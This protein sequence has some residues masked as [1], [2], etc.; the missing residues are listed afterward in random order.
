M[1]FEILERTPAVRHLVTEKEL[2]YSCGFS[3]ALHTG[4]DAEAIGRNRTAL[5]VAFGEGYRFCGIRQTHSDRIHIAVHP[6]GEGWESLSDAVEADAVI[7][8]L[9]QLVLTILTAD[10]VP[11]LLYDPVQRAIGAVHAGWKGTEAEIVI[12]T[13]RKMQMQYGSD[14][15]DIIVAIGPAIGQCC[16]EVGGEVAEHFMGYAGAVIEGNI[17]GKY[18]LDLKRV[19]QLQAEK[20]GISA[21]HIEL[22]PLCTSCAKERFFSY[23]AEQGCG[24]RFV[25]AIALIPTDP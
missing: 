9:P 21:E 10:C 2:G 18:Q 19:N 25:S 11:I 16:Y 5:A 14:P 4:E 17:A 12:Q 3:M 8:D 24:G 20:A 15:R 1:R 23:R 6:E 7:T 13:I 22:T